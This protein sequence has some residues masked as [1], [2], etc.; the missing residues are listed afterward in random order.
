MAVTLNQKSQPSGWRLNRVSLSTASLDSYPVAR[1]FLDRQSLSRDTAQ[2]DNLPFDRFYERYSR[3]EW[4]AI[5]LMNRDGDASNGESFEFE[6]SGRWTTHAAAVP[7]LC[8]V[9]QSYF[10]TDDLKSV[11][12]FCAMQ[13]GMIVPHRDYLEL[14]NGFIRLHAPL[15]TTDLSISTE[16]T[17]AFHMDVGEVWFLN[18]RQTHAAANYAMDPRYH[19]VLDFSHRAHIASLLRN[20]YP[21]DQQVSM[22][23][24]NSRP[25]TFQSRLRS[26]GRIMS[27]NLS[28]RRILHL[29]CDYHFQFESDADEVY[30]W[31]MIAAQASNNPARV[32]TAQEIRAQFLGF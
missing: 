2:L 17:C 29:L 4:R 12:I 23:L 9:V 14:P 11:R 24:R 32:I 16:N 15:A 13:G 21:H 7:Y 30:E 8:H 22:C 26:I 1:I 3:G 5:S 6:G 10:R 20:S 25:S 27:S 28:V 18:A 19:L 31:L